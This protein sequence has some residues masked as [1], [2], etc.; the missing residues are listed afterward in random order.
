MKSCWIVVKDHKAALEWREVPV[1][2]PKPD[3]VVIKVHA[4]AM[5]RGELVVGGAVHG[6]P[7]KLGGTEASGV[8]HAVGSAIKNVKPGD[9][10]FGRARGTF[11]EYAVFEQAQVI[12]LPKNLSFE[13]GAATPIS[14]ITAYEMI[15]PP[16]GKLK[17]GETLLIT[18]ASAGAA[19]ASLS[20]RAIAALASPLCAS[21]RPR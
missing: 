5:N 13:E 17:A 7:E 12:P 15:Y 8:V 6:G 3:Q 18:G 9:R 10:I 2:Q 21:P 1:P 4:A 16:Y 19:V 11:A 14:Y 20:Q